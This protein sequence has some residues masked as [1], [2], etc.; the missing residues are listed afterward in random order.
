[1]PVY[2][3]D[4]VEGMVIPNGKELRRQCSYNSELL[5]KLLLN[6]SLL[7]N[8]KLRI[9]PFFPCVSSPADVPVSHRHL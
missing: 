8:M 9:F 3:T 2:E 5:R 4:M 6:L 7:L 1:M